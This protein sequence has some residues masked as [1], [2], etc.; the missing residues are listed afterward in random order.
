MAARLVIVSG[1][2]QGAAYF[3]KEGGNSI[4]R[5]QGNNITLSSGQISKR[6][7]TIS[8]TGMNA[9]VLDG[10][11]SNGTFI[12]GVLAKKSKLKPGDKLSIGPFVFEFISGPDEAGQGAAF[13]NPIASGIPTDVDMNAGD[14]ANDLLQGQFEPSKSG[15]EKSF[16]KKLFYKFDETVT[17][18]VHDMNTRNE[19]WYIL[20]G[21]FVCYVI[22]YIGMS[23]YPLLE[24]AK[25]SV[26]R[27]AEDRARYIARQIAEINQE[28]IEQGA[29]AN[30]TVDFAEKDASVVEA[31]IL[32]LQGRVLA[33]GIKINEGTTNPYV[34]KVL[35][36]TRAGKRAAWKL[37]TKRNEDNTRLLV[38]VPIFAK[39]PKSG[40]EVPK[41]LVVLKFALTGIALDP[42]MVGVIYL[43]SFLM[44]MLLGLVFLFLVYRL[45]YQPIQI[46]NDELDEVLKGNISAVQKH[47][48]FE[49]L[50]QLI[51]SVNSVLSRIP[52]LKS[53]DEDENLE[54]S[55]NEQ[56]IIDNMMVPLQYMVTNAHLPMMLMDGASNVLTL[57]ATFEELTGMHGEAIS[58][59]PINDA[60]RDEAFAAMMYDMMEKAPDYGPEGVHE[61]YEFSAGLYNIICLSVSSLPEKI[62]AYL[63]SA[64]P[65]EEE[66]YG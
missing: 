52:E 36:A 16:F 31:L 49:P 33:P 53:G 5:E 34:T 56:Q 11:S 64:L 55:D 4:G 61:E 29:E 12:N 23:V 60:A 59:M 43:E 65:A 41:A 3:L 21:L 57:S 50:N 47:Y 38:T 24:T 10:G 26:L 42:G 30:L 45:T 37:V 6:H 20:G 63:V 39:S 44:A 22:L 48:Q 28:A 14:E 13:A 51:D 19:W 8:V 1:P 54:A 46:V 7:C 66:D 40:A 9:E 25:E 17:P 58:G 62:E 32:D 35:R 18:V 15:K 2:N 27:E